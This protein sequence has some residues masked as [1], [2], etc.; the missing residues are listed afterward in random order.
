MGNAARGE[1]VNQDKCKRLA[2]VLRRRT[3][4]KLLNLR[5]Y[6]NRE[7]PGVSRL[8]QA[9]TVVSRAGSIRPEQVVAL[10]LAIKSSPAYAQ[11]LPGEGLVT[12][13][14][15]EDALDGHALNVFEI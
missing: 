12:I 2:K 9:E 4:S 7:N 1:A 14:L 11:H 5:G 6:A 3:L 8:S 15:L 13:Y 10:E